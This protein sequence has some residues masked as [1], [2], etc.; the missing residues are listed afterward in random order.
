MVSPLACKTLTPFAEYVVVDP[1]EYD[2]SLAA[3][4]AAVLP[5]TPWALETKNPASAFTVAG[6]IESAS[7]AI[8][9][10]P[11]SLMRTAFLV[12]AMMTLMNMTR[13]SLC[14]HLFSV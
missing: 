8:S 1:E 11:A 6:F 4:K 3:C 14:K 10:H 9:S 13:N 12:V 5:I 2:S 7:S